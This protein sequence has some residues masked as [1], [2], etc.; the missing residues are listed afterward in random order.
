MHTDEGHFKYN[1]ISEATESDIYQFS[2]N[3]YKYYKRHSCCLLS[4]VH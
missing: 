1:E 4:L 3:D 2:T